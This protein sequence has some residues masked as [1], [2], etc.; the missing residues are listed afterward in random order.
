[1]KSLLRPAADEVDDGIE[2]AKQD[3]ARFA[4]YLSKR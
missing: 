1:V 2:V 3:V 4:K